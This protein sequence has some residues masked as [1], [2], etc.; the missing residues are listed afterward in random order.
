MLSLRMN[1]LPTNDQ[2]RERLAR[3]GAGALSDA[4]LLAIL[5]RVGVS[6]TNVLQLS[7]QLLSDYGGWI[8]LQRAE[9][10]DLCRRSGIGASKA[11]S[12]KAALEIGRRL[13]RISVDERFPIRSP[14]DV[15]ALLMVEMSH[16]DQEHLRTV[17]LD[18][19]NRVQQISTIYIGSLNA[20]TIRIGEVFKEAVRRNS[21]AIIVVHNHPSG[22]ATPSPEDIQVTRQLVA[23][24][25]LLDIEVLDHLIIGR[26]HYVSL[27]ERGLG[28][29]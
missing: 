25:R 11:A 9:Y 29:E 14:A 10:N 18:T 12:I 2:P 3:L 7:Q 24:G 23:A 21:A 6:G 26:G 4:E 27:R 22:E 13:A 1:E 17:L 8:G 28:F 19:K 15:A 20:A 5:L 16:L